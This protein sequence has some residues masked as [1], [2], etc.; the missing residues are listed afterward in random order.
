MR[1][2]DVVAAAFRKRKAFA[3]LLEDGPRL[4]LGPVACGPIVG[5]AP[6][7][8]DWCRQRVDSVVRE[9]SLEC[10][11]LTELSFVDGLAEGSALVRSLDTETESGVKPPHSKE[12]DSSLSEPATFLERLKPVAD[13]FS[14]SDRNTIRSLGVSLHELGDA[15]Q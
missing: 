7:F 1:L 6:S 4:L 9:R 2:G 13:R 5:A 12:A 11:G 14:D 10:S 15:P 3:P 8:V